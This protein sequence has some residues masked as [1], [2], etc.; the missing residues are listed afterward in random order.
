MKKLFVLALCALFA[1]GSAEAR[2]LYVSASRP[3]NSGNGLK[4]TTAKKTIQAAI[5]IAKDGDT[6]LVGAGTYAP[7]RTNN[8]RIVIKSLNGALKTKI[9]MPVRQYTIALAQLGKTYALSSGGSSAPF[10]KGK[11]TALTGFLLD[12][13]NRS[14]NSGSIVALSGGTVRSCSIR[15]MGS[16]TSRIWREAVA[17]SGSTL[18]GCS[19]LNNKIRLADTCLLNRCRLGNNRVRVYEGGYGLVKGGRLCNCLIDNNRT[20]GSAGNSEGTLFTATTLANCTVVANV[21][22]NEWRLEHLSARSKLYNC[23]LREN[24]FQPAAGDEYWSEESIDELG[25]PVIRNIDVGNAYSRTYA[26]NRNPKFVNERGGDYRLAKGSPCINQGGFNSTLAS[27]LGS[28][29]LGGNKRIRG[30]KIDMGCY[31]Y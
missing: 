7:I 18:I 26:N 8:K 21:S 20:F 1:V 16:D 14:L 17:A 31:E 24:Y 10:S 6:I 13:M 9:V 19:F 2:T 11:S 12:G 30:G 4:P 25:L 15:R 29:D 27:W 3:D 5:N 23:I 22:Y 28:F